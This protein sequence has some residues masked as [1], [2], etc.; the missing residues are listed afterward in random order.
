MTSSQPPEEASHSAAAPARRSAWSARERVVRLVWSTLGRA[1]WAVAPG[2]RPSL[3]R[4]FGARVGRGCSFHSTS[5]VEIPWNLRMG[6]RVRVGRGVRLYSLGVITIGDDSA[7][8]AFAHLCAGTHDHTDP[9]F[10]LLRPPVTLGARCLIGVDAYIGPGV[11]LGDGCVVSARSS[12][13][14]SKPAGSVLEG[15]PAKAR[16]AEASR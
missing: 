3:L 11:E 9:A 16:A 10:P 8:D 1:V 13:H 5:R 15:N 6:D 4:W 12:V 14:S 7:L 2:L